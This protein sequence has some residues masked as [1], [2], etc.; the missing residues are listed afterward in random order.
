MSSLREKLRHA[1]A[2]DPP[3]PAQPTPEQQPAVDW[4]CHQVAKRHLTTPGLITLEISRPLNW[5]AAQAMH[6]MSPGVWALAPPKS[7][8]HYQQFAAFLE[9]RG[10][11][12][13]LVRRIEQ[14]E[15][16]YLERERAA[17]R[18]RSA[19]STDDVT[20]PRQAAEPHEE[21]HDDRS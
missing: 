5:L 15:R 12:E 17:R 21:K 18:S 20:G 10:S 9:Q 2:V 8:E 11:T 13:Y 14:M 7:H 16:E 4:F 3:G 1:F 19:R 6:V